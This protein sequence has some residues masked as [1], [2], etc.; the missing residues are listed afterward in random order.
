MHF[1]KVLPRNQ[2]PVTV[3]LWA[4]INS[5]V[6]WGK[7]FAC[8][9]TNAS[10]SLLLYEQGSAADHFAGYLAYGGKTSG[11]TAWS[12]FE[13]A[14]FGTME[15]LVV[16]I[17]DVS[18]ATGWY[19]TVWTRRTLDGSYVGGGLPNVAG[20]SPDKL[21]QTYP[22]IGGA[23]WNNSDAAATFDEESSWVQRLSPTAST[24]TGAASCSLC[25]RSVR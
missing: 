25:D 12:T 3:E 10:N 4:Q 15:H 18:P 1:A 5:H 7:L 23:W 16:V 14:R 24:S 11:D 9:N 2:G 8:G 17:S 20:W 13:T 22:S 6:N 19:G 21:D